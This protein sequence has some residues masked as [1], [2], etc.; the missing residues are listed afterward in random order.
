M[1]G[2][3][4][5]TT[6]KEQLKAEI[7]SLSGDDETNNQNAK[8]K[9]VIV[10][11]GDDFSSQQYI[12]Y[13]RKAAE[14]IGIDTELV[15]FPADA[16]T[17]EIKRRI[18]ELAV[19]DTCNGIMVQLP[20]PDR[21][22]EAEILSCIPIDKDVDG[23]NPESLSK[24]LTVINDEFVDI[25]SYRKF[26]QKNVDLERSLEA[27]DVFVP[28]TA[29]AIMVM[30]ESYGVVLPGK[31]VTVIGASKIVGIPVAALCAMVGAEVALCNSKTTNKKELCLESDVIIS[32]TGKP[33][34]V[35]G[36]M[37]NEGAV[38]IDVGFSKNADTGKIEGD[39]DFDEVAKKA[40]MISPA[41]GGVGPV[42][43]ACLMKNLIQ[44]VNS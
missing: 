3:Q 39:V 44:T 16:T 37:V 1:D 40:G 6:I 19:D 2:K 36:D 13:K 28:A 21:T 8:P 18:K 11:V 5:A 42:T 31:K 23:L 34:M 38:V 35:T 43:I 15:T 10:L 7:A 29:L 14:E 32:A 27:I 12:K 20:L 17:S 24:L 41:V 30:L 4:L 26:T 33:K 22:S 25:G 9:L